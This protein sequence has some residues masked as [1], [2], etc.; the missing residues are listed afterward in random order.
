MRDGLLEFIDDI[1]GC[2]ATETIRVRAPNDVIFMQ[3][4]APC[5]RTP[6]VLQFLAN[7]KVD[8]MR[9]PAQ[10]PDLNP[11]ENVWHMLKVRFHQ[12]FTDL[13]Y[14]LSKSQNSREKYIE[15][16]Q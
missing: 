15:V 14:A 1:L 3:D 16:F 13:R 4:G 9:W 2:A 12:H 7:E 11:I 8:V 5:H 10:S 6:E